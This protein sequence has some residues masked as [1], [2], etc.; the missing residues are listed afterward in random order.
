MISLIKRGAPQYKVNLHSHSNL[1]D[2]KLSPEELV[3]IYKEHG[4]SALAI[5]DH[6][7]PADHSALGDE[8]FIL[9]TGYEVYIRPSKECV[10]DI[11]S[12]EIH[13]NLIAKEPHNV[14]YV[15]YNPQYCKY[16][17]RSEHHTLVKVGSEAQREYSPEYINGFVRTAKDF[18]YICT[19][20]H[21]VWSLE[22]HEQIVRYEGFFSMEMCNYGAYIA[23]AAEYNAAL[24]DR[25]CRMGKRI[26][27]H[28]ADDNHNVHPIDSP[29][30]DS[31]G[32][33]AMVMADELSYGALIKALEEHSF[34]S[35]M[36]PKIHE[37]TIENGVAHIVTDPVKGLY[38]Y[39][40][41]KKTK[42]TLAEGDTL[43]EAS[44][45]IAKDAPYV[46]FTA[47]D[48]HGRAADTR[49]F[50]RDEFDEK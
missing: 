3:R 26:A 49:A 16:L 46:R 34:Y 1:S 13:F 17:P 30:C 36:G 25:L 48:S 11:Y 12:P 37:L 28:S 31:F 21:P 41:S 10:Y 35:S 6:E 2:G 45:E 24:Y 8:S 9:L 47:R 18:G 15:N 29:K 5:T 14:S 44:F 22:E 32:G 39:S 4:Y 27:C 38:M 42:Y 33:F 23:N 20:N 7:R 50:F 19:Y 40:G 43:T